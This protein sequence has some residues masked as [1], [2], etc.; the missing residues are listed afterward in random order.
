[1]PNFHGTD[2]LTYAI[3]DGNGGTATATVAITVAPVNDAPVAADDSASTDEDTSLVI[4]VLA[5]DGDVDGD[6]LTVHIDTAPSYGS[7]EVN[8]DGTI[9]YTPDANFHGADSFACRGD[10]G[11]GGTDTANVS[12]TINSIN[13]NP[14]ASGDEASTLQG[15]GVVIDVLA[16]DTD[17]DGDV[18]TVSSLSEPAS[19]TAVLNADGTITYTPD[20]S[21]HG[22]DT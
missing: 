18:L 6:T 7:I 16:N 9:T 21:F 15:V 11:S 13:D 5:N 17:L 3:S 20:A 2:S 8:A 12:L 14:Q 22:S 4:A 1:N 10:D 19:G